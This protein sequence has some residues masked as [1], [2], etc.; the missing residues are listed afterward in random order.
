MIG[1]FTENVQEQVKEEEEP[2]PEAPGQETPA[3]EKPKGEECMQGAVCSAAG[4][5][6]RGM[7]M[8]IWVGVA[9]WAVVWG[10]GIR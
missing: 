7:G 6:A 8:A 10:V 9:G 5:T 1:A 2:V 4:R 3:D